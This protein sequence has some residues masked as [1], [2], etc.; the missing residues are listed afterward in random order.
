[1]AVIA[2]IMANSHERTGDGV[3]GSA[4]RPSG[5]RGA[6]DIVVQSSLVE[7]F[8]AYG[9]ALAPSPRIALER[10]P[11]VPEVSA[12][13]G[14]TR[15]PAR[16][17]GRLTLSLPSAVIETMKAGTGATLRGDWVR[18][19]SNQLLGRIKNRMLQFGVRL[20][21]GISSSVD[22]K[23]LA[24]QLKQSADVRLYGGRTLRGEVL[25]SIAGAPADSELRYVAP[26]VV[27][28]EGAA[29]LF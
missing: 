6:L 19:L 25:A 16:K 1:M 28:A 27:A 29:I 26:V 22:A 24:N 10:A 17:P 14:F 11:T 12:A 21:T 8:A 4:E 13:I 18:E 15:L 7:L 23:V 5:V 2:Q 20:E 9:V 3:W